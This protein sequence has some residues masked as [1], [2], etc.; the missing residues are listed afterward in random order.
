MLGTAS[1][2]VRIATNVSQDTEMESAESMLQEEE[3]EHQQMA[4]KQDARRDEIRRNLEVLELLND[5]KRRNKE[6][7]KEKKLKLRIVLYVTENSNE[8]QSNQ[9][10]IETERKQLVEF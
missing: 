7:M 4:E 10:V 1:N 3:M 5:E 9:V 2:S 6:V 8:K